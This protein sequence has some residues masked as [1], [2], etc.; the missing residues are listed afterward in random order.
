M[1]DALFPR[2]GHTA[3]LVI[4]VQQ[5]LMPAIEASRRPSVVRNCLTLVSLA[6]ELGWPVI[7]TE[8]YPRGLGATVPELADAFARVGC[9][10]REKVHFSACRDPGSQRPY[11]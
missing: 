7:A 8:Q 3:L 4:D 6:E 9:V 5:R 2:A 10:P 1:N 11:N